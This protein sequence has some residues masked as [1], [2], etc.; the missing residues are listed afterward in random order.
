[1][2]ENISKL[3]ERGERLRK[4]DETT[5]EMSNEADNFASMAKRIQEIQANKKWWQL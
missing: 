1:M 2:E 4:L 3:H 5:A